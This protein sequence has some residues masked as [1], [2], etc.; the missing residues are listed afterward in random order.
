MSSHKTEKSLHNH[1]PTS[2]LSS[3]HAGYTTGKRNS[4]YVVFS[5]D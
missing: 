1:F 4:V 5:N 2:V 3:Q